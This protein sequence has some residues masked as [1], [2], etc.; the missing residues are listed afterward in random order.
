MCMLLTQPQNIAI[1]RDNLLQ[2]IPSIPLATDTSI[3]RM[4]ATKK[5]SINIIRAQ[6]EYTASLPLVSPFP[7]APM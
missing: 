3:V 6:P 1:L 2:A 7:L 4:H 5:P